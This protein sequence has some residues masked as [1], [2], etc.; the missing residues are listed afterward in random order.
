MAGEVM[1][2]KDRPPPLKPRANPT[3]PRQVSARERAENRAR[4]KR[5]LFWTAV[6]LPFIFVAMAIGYSDQMPAGV[7]AA[8]E[9][10]DA[11]F[12]YPVLRLIALIMG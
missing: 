8:T 6:A 5:F 10:L 9:R 3:V 7:Q 2:R 11:T 1:A 12:G 4:W